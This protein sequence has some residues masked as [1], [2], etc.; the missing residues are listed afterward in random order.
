MWHNFV[1]QKMSIKTIF[2]FIF[3]VVAGYLQAQNNSFE[4]IPKNLDSL[5]VYLKAINSN[6]IERTT[7]EF[8]S[9]IKKLLKD[10]DEK[11]VKS[12]E[13]SIYVFNSSIRKN[14]NN[15]LP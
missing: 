3:F 15:I 10:R 12:I 14:L 9:K 5:K 11:V 6:Q 13:D 2:I 7:G 1:K 4:Y 8:S